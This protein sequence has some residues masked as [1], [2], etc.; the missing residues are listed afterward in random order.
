MENSQLSNP[1]QRAFLAAYAECGSVSR[2]AKSAEISRRSHYDWLARNPDYSDAFR[3]TQMMAYDSLHDE[4]V[5]RAM[6]FEVPVYYRGKMICTKQ[7][8]SDRLLIALLQRIE[9]YKPPVEATLQPASAQKAEPEV[10]LSVLTDEE[11][12]I[13]RRLSEKA[14][15][16]TDSQDARP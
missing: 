12:E 11:F 5:R 2:A 4:A 15:R 1:R 7:V 14:R 6:G 3:R 8:Y 9:P 10:D 16:S 13:L